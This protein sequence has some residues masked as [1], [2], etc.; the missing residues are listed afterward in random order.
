MMLSPEPQVAGV[1]VFLDR[2][3]VISLRQHMDAGVPFAE[4]LS[5]ETCLQQREASN[6]WAQHC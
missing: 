3:R 1:L 5:K 2:E 6:V 4:D